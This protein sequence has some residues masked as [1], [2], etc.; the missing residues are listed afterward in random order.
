MI[1]PKIDSKI[2]KDCVNL[3]VE[4]A[5]TAS[6]MKQNVAYSEKEDKTLVT[7]ADKKVENKIKNHLNKNYSYP[8]VGEE[9]GG[10]FGESDTYWLIDPIDG[11]Q[12]YAYK[13]PFYGTSISLIKNGEPYLGVFYMPELDYL[14]SAEKGEGAYFNNKKINV[15]RGEKNDIYIGVTGK[16]NIFLE[17]SNILSKT[18]KWSQTFTCAIQSECW[19]ACGWT[20]VCI[21]GGLHPWD[22][23]TGV[24]MIREAGGVAKKISGC[25]QSWNDLRTGNFVMGDEDMVNNIINSLPQRIRDKFD[26]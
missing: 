20:D 26:N 16:E 7:E 9:F 25:S 6:K 4:S 14:F 10:D 13:Q 21:C 5:N 24:I 2:M 18:S 15:S 1:N 8:V 22:F 19:A 12:N 3:A 11:T 17:Y 23:S